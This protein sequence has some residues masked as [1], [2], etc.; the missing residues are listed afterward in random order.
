MTLTKR[1]LNVVHAGGMS[2][3]AGEY[4]HFL[5][6]SPAVVSSILARLA[7]QGRVKR[8]R[9]HKLYPELASTTRDAWVY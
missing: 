7:R 6:A 4:A 2:L 9:R 3:S 5:D 1:I 8:F